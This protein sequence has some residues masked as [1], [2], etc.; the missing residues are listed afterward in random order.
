[1]LNRIYDSVFSI[2]CIVS[3]DTR[4]LCDKNFPL[5]NRYLQLRTSMYM[6]RLKY[7]VNISEITLV[8]GPKSPE[9]M[10]TM[11]Q[12][13]LEESAP[14]LVTA[15]L[16]A[17]ER[18]NNIRERQRKEE[19]ERLER[20]A[21]EAEKKQKEEE[22]ARER[23][24]REA[25]EREAKLIKLREEKSVSLGPEPEKG[26]DVTQDMRPAKRALNMWNKKV[27]ET[28]TLLLSLRDIFEGAFSHLSFSR[29]GKMGRMG[30]RLSSRVGQGLFSMRE[31][32]WMMEARH[33][34]QRPRKG[35]RRDLH[36]TQ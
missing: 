9:E 30:Q 8:E 21:A 1:M 7:D 3:L 23:Q 4:D 6:F 26:P 24:A 28:D 27:L 18:R 12:R 22:E 35:V 11:L 19:E 33:A 34:P 17:E 29:T 10:L 15:R 5:G 16:D 2:T 20:E 14:V 36:A 32:G 25:V 13:V 31:V